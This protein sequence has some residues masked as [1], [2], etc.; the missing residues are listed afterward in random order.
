M[1][2]AQ[3]LWKTATKGYI[4]KINKTHRAPRIWYLPIFP[5][6]NKNK[7]GKCRIV[8]DA[9]AKSYGVS[10]NSML[11]KGPDFLASLL[12]ILFKFREKAVAICGDIEQMF[13]QEFIQKQD[14]HVQRFLWRNCEID[15]EP[16]VYIMNVMMFGAS[17]APSISQYVKNLNATNF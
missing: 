10:L 3:K 14:R 11:H 17:C 6:F 15:R 4:S 9:A 7:P 5:V 13:H 16:D 8:W 12:G 1:P 2:L